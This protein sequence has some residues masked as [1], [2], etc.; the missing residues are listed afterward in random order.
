MADAVCCRLADV[1]LTLVGGGEANLADF[2]GQKLILF[3]CPEGDPDAQEREISSYEALADAFEDAGTWLLG[4]AAPDWSAPE[5]AKIN[6]G[7]DPNGSAFAALANRFPNAGEASAAN[8]AAFVIDRDGGV[9][10]F[11]PGLGHARQA[12]EAARERP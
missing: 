6:L 4:V 11:W 8:G 1:P 2:C 7:I 3:F 12:L 9:R 10:H 5:K